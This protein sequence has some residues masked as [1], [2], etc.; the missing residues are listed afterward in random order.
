PDAGPIV[1]GS[2]KPSFVASSAAA[3]PAPA[4]VGPYNQPAPAGAA[5]LATAFNSGNPNGTWSL[6]VIDDVAGN[7][8]GSIAGWCLTITTSGDAATITAPGSSLNPSLVAQS[9]TFSAT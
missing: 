1:G 4:P 5:T 3:F 9:V 6:Y 7:G 2:F 8:S